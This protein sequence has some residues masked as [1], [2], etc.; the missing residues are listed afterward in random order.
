MYVKESHRKTFRKLCKRLIRATTRY[1]NESISTVLRTICEKSGILDWFLWWDERKFHIVPAF[2]GFNLS[3]LNLAESGQSG[4]KP[5]SRKKMHLI[6]A[7]YKDCTQMMRQDES[8]RAYIGNISK[9]IGKGLNIRQIQE[10]DR[11]GQEARA[12]RYADALMHGDVNA[13]TDE[14]EPAGKENV[15]IPTDGARH[16]APKVHSKKNPTQRKPKGKM[17]TNS[18]EDGNMTDASSIHSDEKEDVPAFVDDDF[19]SSVH[20]TKLVFINNTIKRCYGC[21]KP[22]QHDKMVVPGDLVFSRKTRR[23]RPDGAG[24]QVQNKVATN[25]FF[26]A[27]DMACLELEFPKIRKKMIYMGNLTFNQLTPV[28]K[29]YLKLKGYWVAIIANRRLKAA[30]Q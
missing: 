7:A 26:C 6:D 16:R 14:E 1:E 10:R 21:G 8:Y 30:Y 19:V 18:Q 12:K 20:A 15:F 17:Y 25:A 5:K 23:F 9:E 2:R 4:M 29:K 13:K 28:H 11:R 24:R 27:R 3:G 22:F